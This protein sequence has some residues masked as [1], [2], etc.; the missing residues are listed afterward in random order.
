M[1]PK[2]GDGLLLFVFQDDLEDAANV[3]SE[4]GS[5]KSTD[6]I[7]E[8][9]HPCNVFPECAPRQVGPSE[10]DEVKPKF[11]HGDH[12]FNNYASYSANQ[13]LAD[14]AMRREVAAGYA[15]VGDVETLTRKYGQLV[16][17]KIACIVS[18][19]DGKQKVRLIHAHRVACTPTIRV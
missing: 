16:L 2:K 3:I 1:V 14:G 6:R 11:L 13:T 5:I 18:D 7:L 17:S 9:I 10:S 19:K 12:G 15:E 4:E 8:S